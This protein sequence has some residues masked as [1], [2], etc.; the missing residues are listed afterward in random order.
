MKILVRETSKLVEKTYGFR[1]CPQT[2]FFYDH[3]ETFV[4]FICA[5]YSK[6]MTGTT[7]KDGVVTVLKSGRIIRAQ[8]IT[9]YYRKC[10]SP[11]HIFLF[12]KLTVPFFIIISFNKKIYLYYTFW[13]NY[14][15]LKINRTPTEIV[16]PTITLFSLCIIQTSGHGKCVTL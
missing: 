7:G 9:K 13:K 14:N 16:K 15:F 5:I 1:L 8:L 11:R 12:P 2:E 4:D 10:T 6:I 3:F